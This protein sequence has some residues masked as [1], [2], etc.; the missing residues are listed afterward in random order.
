[1]A[2]YVRQNQNTGGLFPRLVFTLFSWVTRVESTSYIW[3][4][5]QS[6]YKG[7]MGL[8][9]FFLILLSPPPL[10][11]IYYWILFFSVRFQ[12]IS[13]TIYNS[14]P[15]EKEGKTFENIWLTCSSDFPAANR[16]DRRVRHRSLHILNG[17][18]W[19]NI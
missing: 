8:S 17:Q 9:R 3:E 1:M 4:L 19:N 14:T 7:I 13:L 5:G 11:E 18:N 12:H 6:I 2:S 16:T 15:F 10:L